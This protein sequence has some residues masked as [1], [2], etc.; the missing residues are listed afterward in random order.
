MK[1]TEV[2]KYLRISVEEAGG[3]C[4]K[5]VSPGRRGVPDRL[6]TWYGRMDLIETKAPGKKPRAEQKR[7]HERRAKL[8]IPVYVIDTKLKV[9]QYVTARR[10]GVEPHWLLTG[11]CA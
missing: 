10:S 11:F 1:E 8:G 6:V 5:H 4:E 2:E 3:L 9:N 7:D